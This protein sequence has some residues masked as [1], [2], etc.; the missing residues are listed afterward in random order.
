MGVLVPHQLHAALEL[1]H[2]LQLAQGQWGAG[3]S[4]RIG[5]VLE[6]EVVGQGRD[7]AV[8]VGA[9]VR[10]HYRADNVQG[11]DEVG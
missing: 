8:G 7:V 4:C 6:S 10:R 1:H 2:Q 3:V 5:V 11:V 9:G